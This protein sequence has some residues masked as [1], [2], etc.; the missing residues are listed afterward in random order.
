M[1]A[2]LHVTVNSDDPSDFGGYVS[3]NLIEC[4]RALSLSLNEIVG[5]ARNGFTAAFI[6]PDERDKARASFDSYVA[7]F[8]M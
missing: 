3:E 7:A 5:L 4:Q 1:S 2:D 6:S 8:K